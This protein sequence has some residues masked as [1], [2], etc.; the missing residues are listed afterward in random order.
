MKYFFTILLSIF[1]FSVSAQNKY[2]QKALLA[3]ESGKFETAN[4]QIDKCLEVEKDNPVVLLLKSK[5]MLSIFKDKSISFEYPSAMKDALKYAE[6]SIE[7][8]KGE[9]SKETFKQ[10]NLDFFKELV[11]LNNKEALESYN[12]N[13]FSKAL[14]LFKKSMFFELDTQSIVCAADCYWQ[15]GQKDESLPLFKKAAELIY[16]A[17][18]DSNSKI[19]GYHKEPFRKLCEYYVGIE[20]YDSAYL[21][22][23][24]GREILP[25]DPKLGEYTYYLMRYQLDRIPPSF[26]Y[27]NA[28]KSGLKDFPFDSFLNHRENSI[29]IYLLN[30]MAD[31]NEQNGFDSLLKIYASTKAE[32]SKLKQIETVKKFDIFAGMEQMEFIGK[33]KHYFVLIGLKNAAYA[34][35]RSEYN[36]SAAS[37]TPEMMQKELLASISKEEN[38][39]LSEIVFKRHLDLYPKQTDF[40]KGL[41]I[42]TSSKNNSGISYNHLQSLISLNDMSAQLN[43]KMPDF[44]LKAKTHRIRLISESADSGDFRL[45]RMVWNEAKKLY[46]D[47]SKT[48]DEY[49]IKIVKND[50]VRNYYGS[51]INPKGKNEKNVP[52][53]AWNGFADSCK[54]GSISD[55][56]VLRVEQRINYFRRMSG[57]TEMI[58]LTRQDNEY[59]MMAA[60]MCEA[61]KSMSHDPNDGWR[62]FI[63]AGADALKNA[64]LSKDANPAIAVTAAMGQNHPTAGNRRWLLYPNAMYMGI[65]T[66]KTYTA[67]KAIDN[68]QN[69]DTNKYKNQYVCWPPANA[70]PKMLVFKKWSFS[71]DTDLNGAVVS[72]KD[73]SGN[74]IELKQDAYAPGYGLNTIVWEPLLNP[75]AIEDGTI[76]HINIKLKNGKNYSYS[77]KVIN[78]EF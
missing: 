59:A 24:N 8:T 64:I 13:R 68:S 2:Y 16:T 4:K 43:P 73:G 33:L 3:Y 62:C 36:F 76:Y 58:S 5:I 15:M 19:Y 48:L 52:E 75:S 26:D 12:L 45:S 63:P 71:L 20:E 18:L 69:I 30:G 1:A 17:V 47:Q 14:P 7:A 56:I 27:L 44:K 9:L 70:C 53:Y 25:N 39:N 66:S 31:A 72:M 46:P 57:L 6:K 32:K 23:K 61:N 35:W 60:L 55:D 50:F 37:K 28:V 51:R 10:N 78:V 41:P 77:F 21:F 40:T 54:W 67:I 42:Y 74:D 38:I 65:G 11:N 34:T 29:Y 49:W 22:V